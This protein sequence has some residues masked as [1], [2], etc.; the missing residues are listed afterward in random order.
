MQQAWGV[1]EQAWPYHGSPH[2]TTPMLWSK[3]DLYVPVAPLTDSCTGTLASRSVLVAVV[4]L[5]RRGGRPPAGRSRGGC[6]ANGAPGAGFGPGD[7]VWAP[8]EE[9][10]GRASLAAGGKDA[11]AGAGG[12]GGAKE[13][14]KQGHRGKGQGGRG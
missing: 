8:T 6:S 14:H 11:A 4:A 3:I 7:G 12:P 5:G 9:T 10:A 2:P 13:V 1:P